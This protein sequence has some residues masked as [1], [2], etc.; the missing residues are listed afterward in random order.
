[1]AQ[2]VKVRLSNPNVLKWAREDIGLTVP[3]V[4]KRFNKTDAIVEAWERGEEAPTFRQKV[5]HC[6]IELLQNC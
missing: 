4:A 3:E 5:T 1:M 2:V 6:S